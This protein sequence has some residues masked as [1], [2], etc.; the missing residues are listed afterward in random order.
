MN[1][2]L[3]L[4]RNLRDLYLSYLNSPFALRYSD[5]VVERRNLLDRNGYL[6][7]E[8]LIEPVPAYPTIRQGFR[9]M[10]HQLLDNNW[11]A[12]AVEEVADF[13][14]C[15]AL[16]A[17]LEPYEHQQRAFERS[18]VGGNDVVVTTGTGSG[19]TECFLLPI[20]TNLVR[21]S[22]GWGAPA[23]RSPQWDWWSD[24]HKYFQ[25]QNIRYAPR[26][27]Q[28]AHEDRITRPAA[29]R[30]LLLYPLNA[31]VEDQLIRLREALDSAPARSWLDSHRCG[32]RLYFGR[33][34]G[35]TPISGNRNSTNTP[36]L[37]TELR[38]MERDAQLVFS[39][40]VARRFFAM[41]DG[42]EMWS[43]WDMQDAPPDL[44]ITNYSML[45]IMLMRGIEAN[46]FDATRRWLEDGR[47][48]GDRD[49]VFHLVVDELHTYRGTPGTEV[50][51]LLR[52][53]L[54]RLGLS[55]DSEQL[56][57]IASSASLEAGVS[58]L[59]YLEGFFGRNRSRF[60]V[61]R[62]TP[63]TP[64]STA[65]AAIRAHH[66]AFQVYGRSLANGDATENDRVSALHRAVGCVTNAANTA[67]LLNDVVEETRAAEAVRA[68]CLNSDG[69]GLMPRTPEE[70]GVALFGNEL[71]RNQREETMEGVLACIAGAR[72]AAASA[73]LPLR[74]HLFFRNVQ[75]VWACT[76]PD[77][78]EVTNRAEPC[79]VGA[80][81]YQ[82]TLSCRC[83]CRVLELLV[84][85]S[86]GEVFLGG[87]RRIDPQNPGVYFLSPDHPD[88][89]A[90][91]EIA[92]LN[93]RF[94]NYAVFWPAAGSQQPL[95]GQ[96]DQDRVRRRWQLGALNIREGSITL[97]GTAGRRGFL[98]HVPT[99]AP[100]ADQAYPAIC[101]RCD[102]DRRRR[103]LDTPIRVMRT[104]F[105]KIAQVLSDGL[106]REMSTVVERSNRKLVVFSDSRQDAAKLSAGMRFAHYRDALRQS[107]AEGVRTAGSG[108]LAFRDQLAGRS[109][110][111]NS[112][113]LAA[114]FARTHPI[115]AQILLGA[116]NVGFA[117]VTAPGFGQL[118]YAQAAQQLLERAE[119]GPFPIPQLT[120]DVGARLLACG[121]NPGGFGQ[122]VLW[123]RSPTSRS[124]AGSFRV[125]SR[126]TT[127]TTCQLGARTTK[128]SSPYRERH[129]NGN[130]GYSVR[131]RSP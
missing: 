66:R 117:N 104:G 46:I 92:F 27:P 20:I 73:P 106:L 47:R 26:I 42:A 130:D 82:P 21:E 87:Y 5:L 51:Y 110:D 62:G 15:G 45:N 88:L 30:A 2:P 85:E 50:A 60:Y 59:A 98:Y 9:S 19:K 67:R 32:N 65:M 125:E 127:C 101:P 75:G 124:M 81:H 14:A 4:F 83:G 64:D 129:P 116:A 96:W 55:A 90:S 122:Q 89:E 23:A 99:P 44:L 3:A 103:R 29:I 36:R 93:R 86:C 94:Q 123:T 84:C 95:T 108:T 102:E 18:V 76:N 10:A 74:A 71:D 1:N 17:D 61:E 22:A 97:G 79:P 24:R 58:G 43:R 78:T 12:A 107:L 80:V 8:P 121:M 63:Q 31:L 114:E 119:H 25:G 33:Y 131:V 72:S 53:L 56:R 6:W 128:P 126:Y 91:P 38:E 115:E 16:A 109:L 28:R 111:A 7:R 112:Q 34:T 68:A 70:L 120:I 100:G 13:V 118:T 48:S 77:C 54:D 105:Q 49:R 41:M 113:R 52:V 11:G 35:R 40:P 39:D 69:G 37:R 57:I